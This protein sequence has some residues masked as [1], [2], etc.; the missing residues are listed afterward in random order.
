MNGVL[1]FCFHITRSDCNTHHCHRGLMLNYSAQFGQWP[2]RKKPRT[3]PTKCA[4]ILQQILSYRRQIRYLTNG[5]GNR[6][7]NDEKRLCH[8]YWPQH[9]A[10]LFFFCWH[11]ATVGC[12]CFAVNFYFYLFHAIA[13]CV[14]VS[15]SSWNSKTSQF[16]IKPKH[17]RHFF[18][19]LS[20]YGH[21]NALYCT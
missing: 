13:L 9:M 8:A 11:L 5:N 3:T 2:N 18:F 19:S 16:W 20:S 7:R 15:V 1:F 4:P 6:K 12:V 21:D 14:W 17:I 10:F